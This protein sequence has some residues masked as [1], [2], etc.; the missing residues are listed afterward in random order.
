MNPNEHPVEELLK[1]IE[2]RLEH[3]ERVLILEGKL[4][5]KA[6]EELAAQVHANTAA[7]ASAVQLIK[8][9][10]EQL[11]ASATDPVQVAALAAQ[12]KASADALAAA[13]V[14]NTP[15]PPPPATPLPGIF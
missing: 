14:A 3:L 9:L 1:R 12:L 7:E 8:G 11:T 6:L 2:A 13:V 10:A 4:M 5:T 15:P